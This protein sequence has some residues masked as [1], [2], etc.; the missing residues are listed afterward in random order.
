MKKFRHL[1]RCRHSDTR[2]MLAW[3]ST[4]I[5]VVIVPQSAVSL[6]SSKTLKFKEIVELAL[7]TSPTGVIWSRNRPLSAMARHFI[8]V[9][10]E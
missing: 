2:S 7:R 8:E 10:V 3:A 1:L 6:M 9:F 5:G 4:G